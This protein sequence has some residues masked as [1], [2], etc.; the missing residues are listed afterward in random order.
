MK[1]KKEVLE[2]L[3][4]KAKLK[5]QKALLSLKILTNEIIGI[6]DH[7]TKDLYLNYDEAFKSYCD[8]VDRLN[9]LKMLNKELD[10]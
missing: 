4:T 10:E 9:N 7:T 5:K 1:V 8:A 3:E 6:G 2:M